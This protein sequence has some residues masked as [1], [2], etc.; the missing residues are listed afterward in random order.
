MEYH[1]SIQGN[2]Q[3]KG[4]AT[5][6]FR[7]ISRAATLAMPGDTV[8]VHAGVYREWVNPVN[9]GTKEHRIIYRSAG[10][11]EVVITGA[12]RIT[13]WVAEGDNVWT[14]KYLIPYLTNVTFEVELW[15]TAV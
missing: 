5:Q 3:A 11:G 2:D 8:I 9:G 7:T 4:N 10:D 14:Q 1:V 12:E 6:P 13:D 15:S